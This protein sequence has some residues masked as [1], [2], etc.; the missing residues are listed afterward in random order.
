MS[1]L[2]IAPKAHF[3]KK[4]QIAPNELIYSSTLSDS[5][6]RL[7]LAL[8]ALPESWTIVQS[9]IMKRLSWN[10]KKM[11]KVIKECVKAGFMRVSQ[12]RSSQGTFCKNSFDFRL[13]PEFI[14]EQSTVHPKT[15]SGEPLGGEPRAVIDHLLFL[16]EVSVIVEEECLCAPPLLGVGT[17][18]HSQKKEGGLAP[19]ALE[20]QDFIDHC[21]ASPESWTP[22]EIDVAWETYMS[23]EKKIDFPIKYLNGIL[24]NKRILAIFTKNKTKNKGEVKKCLIKQSKMPLENSNCKTT[25]RGTLVN[26]SEICNFRSSIPDK[27]RTG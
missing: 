16:K 15:A 22:V 27:S 23:S 17:A 25:G 20:K 19:K 26:L 11:T 7:L 24:K 3:L 4:S 14:Q 5:A 18:V 21:K 2:F 6:V 1:G 9:D 13:F 12:N 8:H 10:T